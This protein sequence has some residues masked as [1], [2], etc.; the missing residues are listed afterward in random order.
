MNAD[1][2]P[3]A[4]L[5]SP[6]GRPGVRTP[7]VG[8][9]GMLDRPTTRIDHQVGV[10]SFADCAPLLMRFQSPRFMRKQSL[11]APLF[12]LL[13]SMLSLLAVFYIPRPPSRLDSIGL[14]AM[15]SMNF[16]IW[17]VSGWNLIQDVERGYSLRNAPW[18]R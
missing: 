14:A 4:V 15:G 6:S 13:F 10:P 17:L 9:S 16:T 18:P 8:C 1:S 11:S 12:T 3:R 5:T 2:Q 7:L